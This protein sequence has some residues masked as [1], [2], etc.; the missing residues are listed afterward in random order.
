[1]PAAEYFLWERH[2]E[3]W[4]PGDPFAQR[5]LA[6]LC[7]L[8]ANAHFGLNQPLRAEDFAPWLETPAERERRAAAKARTQGMIL[9]QMA[10]DAYMRKR[11]GNA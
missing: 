8:T 6:V 10:G 3:R 2:F 5:L 1:M 7:A 9:M 4:P 11:G